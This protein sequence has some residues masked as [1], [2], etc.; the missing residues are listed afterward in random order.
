MMVGGRCDA[1]RAGIGMTINLPGQTP[2]VND[3]LCSVILVSSVVLMTSLLF[4][5]I[6]K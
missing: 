5:F 1:L 2:T 6:L 3:C 4:F